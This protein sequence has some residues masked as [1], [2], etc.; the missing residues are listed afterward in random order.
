MLVQM[1]IMQVT[2]HDGQQNW[3]ILFYLKVITQKQGQ[4]CLFCVIIILVTM[5]TESNI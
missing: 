1:K 5:A 2:P 3:S 4:I